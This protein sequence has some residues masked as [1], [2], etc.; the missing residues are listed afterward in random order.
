MRRSLVLR[1]AQS[2]LERS[3]SLSAAGAQSMQQIL[4]HCMQ[5]LIALAR[6][7]SLLVHMR[8]RVKVSIENVGK[9]LQT[10]TQLL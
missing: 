7:A 3:G 4:P 1:V 9:S 6:C 5:C 8:G 2:S 10:F